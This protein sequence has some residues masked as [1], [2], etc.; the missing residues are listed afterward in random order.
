M[1]RKPPTRTPE[2]LA[3]NRRN[4]K[5]STGPR[6][7]EGKAVAALNGLKHG[8]YALRLPEMLVLAGHQGSAEFYHQLRREI[9]DA[10]AAWQPLSERQLDHL[11]T[12]VWAMARRA[13]VLGRKP[14]S[15]VFPS[16]SERSGRPPFQIRMQS[17]RGR[18]A[19][20]YWVQRKGRG[21]KERLIGSLATGEPQG[22]LQLREAGL[23]ME[24]KLR[25]RVFGLPSKASRTKSDA[26]R[27]L[28][29]K[30]A[31]PTNGERRS[32][33]ES[34]AGQDGAVGGSPIGENPT[35]TQQG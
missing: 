34:I 6:T 10:F 9:A 31:I 4:A 2:F 3:A 18:V 16:N 29:T 17:P 19:L 7:Q 24:S 30:K 23:E 22:E 13:G 12:Q 15:S 28:G 8:G 33:W 32:A 25:R 35:Q 20:I 14:E 26:D 1:L 5:K 27:E 21:S 11:A